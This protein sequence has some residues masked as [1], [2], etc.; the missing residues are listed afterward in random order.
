MTR[1]T[2]DSVTRE[3]TQYTYAAFVSL[4]FCDYE[5]V[6]KQ[7]KPNLESPD[8][9]LYIYPEQFLSDLNEDNIMRAL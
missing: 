2:V 7:M 5:W 3:N 4:T 9:K 6:A 8:F 1:L